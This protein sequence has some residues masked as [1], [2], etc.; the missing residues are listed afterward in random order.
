MKVKNNAISYQFST[1]KGDKFKLPIKN[2]V[3]FYEISQYK[4][5]NGI[6]RGSTFF[7]PHPGTIYKKEAIKL[8]IGQPK[9]FKN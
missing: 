1:Q 4:I 9:R 5:L 6:Y 3:E 8:Q 7:F 2:H